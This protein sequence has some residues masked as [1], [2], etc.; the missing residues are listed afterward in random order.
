MERVAGLVATLGDLARGPALRR[1]LEPALVA[2]LH[3]DLRSVLGQN[4]SAATVSQ[5]KTTSSG[6]ASAI[7][8]CGTTVNESSHHIMV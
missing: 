5:C 6:N 2:L 3:E 1:L 7:S 8:K 4:K